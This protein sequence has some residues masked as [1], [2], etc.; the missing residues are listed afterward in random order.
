MTE[1][2]EI[3]PRFMPWKLKSGH[4]NTDFVEFASE[5]NTNM[6]RYVAHG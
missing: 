5:I 6:P 4:Y 2:I 3:N 1:L